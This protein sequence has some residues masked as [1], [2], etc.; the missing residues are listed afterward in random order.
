[1]VPSLHACD[2]NRCAPSDSAF[3]RWLR[4][5]QFEP[6]RAVTSHLCSSKTLLWLRIPLV[7]YTTSVLGV[8]IVWHMIHDDFQH[9]FA[10]FTHYTFLGLHA[11]LVVRP[12][13]ASLHPPFFFFLL[14]HY[15]G[16]NK[17]QQLPTSPQTCN[18]STTFF[19]PSESESPFRIEGDPFS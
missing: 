7:L 4:L 15:T 16:D 19:S 8:D 2:A 10:Y 1:M 3:V 18:S 14:Y 12:T 17:I 5:D 6:E 9:Y 13:L 11:Y